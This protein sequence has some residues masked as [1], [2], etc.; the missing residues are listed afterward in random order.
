[1][2]LLN[3]YILFFSILLSG[4]DTSD[5]FI[6]NNFNEFMN[7]SYNKIDDIESQDTK[8]PLIGALFSAI[9]PGAGQMYNGDYKRGIMYMTIE[10][11]SSSYRKN[12]ISKSEEY[13]NK[14]KEFADTHWSFNKW[15]NDYAIFANT[16]IN[17]PLYQIHLTMTGSDGE[18]FY[19]WD[20]SHHIEFY[21]YGTLQRTNNTAGSNVFYERYMSECGHVTTT[22]EACNTDYFAEAIVTKDHHLYEG[23]GK[24]D[25]FFAG[26]DDS[27]TDGYVLYSGNTNNALSPNKSYYQ[28]ELRAKANKKSDYAENA[29]TLIFANHAI[30]MFDAFI[31]N[32]I[33]NK[34]VNFNY[35]SQPIYNNSSTL[36]LEGINFSILW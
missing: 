23:L 17:G 31:S 1:M 14:Y 29:L 18:F 30:S 32:L 25:L 22:F 8:N 13:E 34:D 27:V 7:S 24:Y 28:Y 35:Y 9:L 16:D 3:I 20:D 11:L 26:W 12:Y 21:N 36:K 15:V 4:E 2:R 6:K 5:S 10:L 19:P 33:K